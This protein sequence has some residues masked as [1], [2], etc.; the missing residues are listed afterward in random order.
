MIAASLTL[1]VSILS[2]LWSDHSVAPPPGVATFDP[3]Q[4]VE[5][6]NSDS[7]LDRKLVAKGEA[8][9]PVVQVPAAKVPVDPNLQRVALKVVFQGGKPAVH[10]PIGVFLRGALQTWETDERGRLSLHLPWPGLH[11][12]YAL[13]T[14]QR[15]TVMWH[16]G[17][18]RPR[19][20]K[21]RLE[22]EAGMTLDVKV[23]DAAGKPVPGAIVESGHGFNASRTGLST[24]G[25][26]DANGR[27]VRSHIP[28]RRSGLRVWADG[29]QPSRLKYIGGKLGQVVEQTLTLGNVGHRVRGM[30]VDEKGQPIANAQLA[31]VQLTGGASEPQMLMSGDDGKFE[32]AT[33][34]AGRHVIVGMDNDK[35]MRRGQ[36]RFAHNGGDT[37]D[38]ELRLTRGARIVGT[39][40]NQTGQTWAGA[41]LVARDRPEAIHSLP[42]LATWTKSAAGGMFAMEGLAAGTYALE[43]EYVETKVVTLSEGETFEWSPV[44]SAMQPMK[45]RLVDQKGNP[46]SGWRV[47]VLPPGQDWVNAAV[48]TGPDGRLAYDMSAFYFEPGTYC[49]LAIYKPQGKSD[50]Q[51]ADFGSIPSLMTPPLTVGLEHELRVPASA[52][53]FH[54]VEGQVVDTEGE[55]MVGATVRIYG[56]LGSSFGS[57]AAVDAL[58]MFRFEG[59][60]GGRRRAYVKISGRPQFRLSTIAVGPQNVTQLGRIE[61]PASGCIVVSVPEEVAGSKKLR[62][63]LRSEA[64]H[65]KKLRKQKDGTWRSDL[66]YYGNYEVTGWTGTAWAPPSKVVLESPNVRADVAFVPHEASKVT[67]QLPHDFPRNAGSWSGD[68]T[69]RSNGRVVFE[70]SLNYRFDGRFLDRMVFSRAL[71]PGSLELEV[72]AWNKRKGRGRLVVPPTGGGEVVIRIE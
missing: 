43:S 23:V 30:V 61:I 8:E 42:F 31:L 5:Q 68:L 18:R 22:I 38:V 12:I 21:S 3:T 58:G 7:E 60:P 15:A 51:F 59:I 24:L 46:L 71:P 62:L 50:K 47:A 55:P 39:L 45:V 25:R 6:A 63:H 56:D 17:Q 19:V 4:V 1:V 70:G 14:D 9:G 2:S 66:L 11:E 44:R 40:K 72:S 53:T 69:V 52:N 36:L 26:T 28:A 13:G 64:G 35:V 37:V 27:F 48:N 67:V 16:D 54:R 41:N 29:Y 65:S 49:R 34:R 20:V 33:L 10:V 57:D 32:T